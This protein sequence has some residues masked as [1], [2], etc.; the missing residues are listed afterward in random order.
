MFAR[1][2]YWGAASFVV[3]AVSPWHNSAATSSEKVIEHVTVKA[4]NARRCLTATAPSATAP[5][6]KETARRHG[7]GRQ[8]AAHCKPQSLHRIHAEKVRRAGN[9]VV[10]QRAG[11]YD[12]RALATLLCMSLHGLSL[13]CGSIPRLIH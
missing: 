6:R 13:R 1:Q 12:K 7:P 4:T 9:L 2:L 10:Q 11:G 8:A 3:V 5:T